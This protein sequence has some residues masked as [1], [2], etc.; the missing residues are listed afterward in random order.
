MHLVGSIPL[1]CVEKLMTAPARIVGR[2]I[3][4][5]V[6]IQSA[7]RYAHVLASF[8]TITDPQ[9]KGRAPAVIRS[10]PSHMANPRQDE[11]VS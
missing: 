6:H 3:N 8:V 5:E 10:G 4:G 1:G 9:F 7:A 2:H 11:T